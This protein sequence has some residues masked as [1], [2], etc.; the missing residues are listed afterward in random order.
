MSDRIAA[1]IEHRESDRD[2]HPP[3]DADLKT[4]YSFEI[5]DRWDEIRQS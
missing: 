5:S 1:A 2:R 4:P 3:Q